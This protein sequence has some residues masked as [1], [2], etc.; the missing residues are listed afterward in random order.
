MVDGKLVN[1]GVYTE[2]T[3]APTKV[4]GFDVT[5]VHDADAAATFTDTALTGDFYNGIRGGG[6][7]GSGPGSTPQGK[8][9]VLTFDDST[10]DG[11]I[12]AST[13]DHA[14]DTITA[15]EYDQLGKVT[16]TVGPV[17][18][19]G[20]IVELAG[21]SAWTVNGTSYL[22][23]LTVG[24]D[25]SVLAPAGKT[26]SMSVD[27]VITPLEAGHSYTGNLVLTLS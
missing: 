23:S 22:S 15:A 24:P 6:T 11:V 5:A 2:P 1:A 14:V 13:T 4:D 8:N 18:N 26:L 21:D 12:S 20:V 19:N 25:A 16:N 27:G 17:V 10:V 7:G 3:T 9:L